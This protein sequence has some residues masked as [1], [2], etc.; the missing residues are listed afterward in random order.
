MAMLVLSAAAVATLLADAAVSGRP[1]AVAFAAV[2]AGAAALHHR[3]R[4]DA[5]HAATAADDGP[6]D[7]PSDGRAT[8]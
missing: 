4:R 1:S 2:I 8:P 5:D 6:A 7:A 3:R